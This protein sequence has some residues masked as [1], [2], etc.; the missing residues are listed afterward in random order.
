MLLSSI[1]SRTCHNDGSSVNEPC[2]APF[3]LCFTSHIP[4]MWN[5][6]ICPNYGVT[7]LAK[8]LLVL[9]HLSEKEF[10]FFGVSIWPCSP[11][12]NLALDVLVFQQPICY[13]AKLF[14]M[15]ADG[16]K[17]QVIRA[18]PTDID[19]ISLLSA[20]AS[21]SNPVTRTILTNFDLAAREAFPRFLYARALDD[22]TSS[23]VVFKATDSQGV[24]VGC[25]WLQ[26]F[27]GHLRS[28]IDSQPGCDLPILKP[29]SFTIPA[30]IRKENYYN[31]LVVQHHHRMACMESKSSMQGNGHW[32]K[33]SF[34]ATTS[35][36]CRDCC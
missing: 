24:V 15:D 22:S 35:S 2:T 29:F 28:W 9:V 20:K 36:K 17:I 32:C 3:G 21:E 4:W 18:G 7:I 34:P 11:P 14:K 1:R 19:E 27:H 16:E 30:C 6:E 23:N 25:V 26:W 33:L 12:P 13:P 8:L 10:V 5:S 31:S